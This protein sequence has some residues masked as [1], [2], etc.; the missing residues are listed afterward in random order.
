M[1]GIIVCNKKGLEMTMGMVLEQRREKKNNEE[2]HIRMVRIW[3]LSYLCIA[4]K[5]T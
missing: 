3:L 2:K 5:V 1:Y 4:S